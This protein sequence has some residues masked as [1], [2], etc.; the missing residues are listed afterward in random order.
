VDAGADMEVEGM[1]RCLCGVFCL[2]GV[3]RDR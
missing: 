1:V 3:E 2:E